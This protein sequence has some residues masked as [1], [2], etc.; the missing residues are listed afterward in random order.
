MVTSFIGL[1]KNAAMIKNQN[2]PFETQPRPLEF[3]ETQHMSLN[4]ELKYLY[5]AV[6]RA[7]C[8]LWI[9]DS[10]KDK[11][12][13]IFDYWHKRGLVKVIQIDDISKDE[14]GLFVTSSTKQEWK[15]QGDYFKKKRLWEPA[16][17]CYQKAGH[18]LL[19]ME[20]E[21]YSL[22]QQAREHK[23]KEMQDLYLKAALAFLNCDQFHNEVKL[24]A[25]AATCLKN[26]KKYSD[27]AKLFEKLGQVCILYII[28]IRTHYHSVIVSECAIKKVEIVALCIAI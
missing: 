26:A 19:E 16:K 12:L 2:L 20:A 15:E 21:A 13:P 17:K 10:D 18:P 14:S 24:L 3:S 28:L 4:S 27:A 5:T 8:N 1:T 25:I 23:G 9:Y 22:V 6:T 11:R 7:K